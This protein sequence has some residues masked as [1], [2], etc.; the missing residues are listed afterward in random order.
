[1]WI[2]GYSI[3]I[4]RL[5]YKF[6]DNLGKSNN[7]NAQ[8]IEQIKYILKVMLFEII[9]LSL[10]VILFS[11]F[12]YFY[13]SLFIIFLMA[14]TKPF[15]GGYHEDTQVKCFIATII[16][17][18]FIIFLAEH[19]RLNLISCIMVNLLSI[20]SIYNRAPVIDKRMPISR[21]DLIKRNRIIGLSVV[22]IL[23]IVS[24]AIYKFTWIPQTIV[25]T[26]LVQAIL[27]FNKRI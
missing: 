9:K 11:I 16:L 17:V 3:M 21:E 10:T 4:E 27:M 14:I 13:E 26:I 24:I 15:I 6:V 12:G 20:F 1:M 22:L 25:W 8:Q 18:F 19:S 7:Y 2:K 5:I 23:S